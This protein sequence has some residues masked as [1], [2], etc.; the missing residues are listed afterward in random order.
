MK[1]A[2][3]THLHTQ[4]SSLKRPLCFSALALGIVLGISGCSGDDGEN[5]L[6]GTPGA[7]G[8][9]GNDGTNGNPGFSAATFILANNGE[10]NAG[11]V[12]LIN[13]DAAKLKTFNTTANEGVAFDSLGNLIQASDSENGSIKTICQLANRDDGA[14]FSTN[15]DREITGPATTLVNPKG[16]AIAKNSGLIFIADFGAMQITTFGS[17]AAGDAAP[18]ATTVTEAAPW[19]VDYDHVNDRLYVALTNGDVAVYDNFVSGEFTAMPSRTITPSDADGVQISVNIHGIV[20]DET[21]NKLILSDVGSASDATDGALFVINNASTAQGNTSVARS[22]S[23]PAT[24]LGNPVDITLE[25]SDLRVAEKSNDA[26]LVFSNIFAGESGDI[27]PDLSTASTKPESITNTLTQSSMADISD[28]TEPNMALL[29]VAVSSNPSTAGDTTGQISR[30]NTALSSELASYNASQT[31]ESVSFDK[32]GNSYATFDNASTGMGGIVI[33][34]KVAYNRDGET[35]NASQDRLISGSNT[36]LISPKGLDIASDSG[37]IFVA[38][39]NE[40]T[41]SIAI[42]SSCATGDASPLM[43]LTFANNARPWDVDYDSNTDRAFVALTNGT[44]AV[45][46]QVKN[47]LLSGETTISTEDRLI[48]PANNSQ[49]LAAPT[50]IHGIDYDSLSGALILSDVGSAAVADDGKIYVL[51]NTANASGLVNISATI[52][53]PNTLLG[54]PVDIMYSGTNLYVAEKSNNVVMRFNNI[55][56]TAGGDISADAS[57]AFS[58]PESVAILPAWLNQ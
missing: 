36:G 20:Y 56:S 6:A 28:S 48:T 58:A 34:T 22:I 49:A 37:M 31:I 13:Q 47:K 18:L 8:Q 53:G 51:N 10:Q 55:L 1:K 24:M 5:G 52:S 16:I 33:S 12:D 14:S 9:D 35:F 46:D 44:V 45:F 32:A 7:D 41:P 30:L 2:N 29:G 3:L 40:T 50:N 4:N 57:M 43:T 27:A 25:G 11:T 42:F 54:N 17:A 21:T 39:N 23:G 26:I 19:D 38:E 15:Q